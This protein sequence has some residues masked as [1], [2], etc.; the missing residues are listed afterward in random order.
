MCLVVR[1]SGPARHWLPAV[2]SEIRAID[3]NVPVADARSMEEALRESV[4][5]PQFRTTAL[6]LSLVRHSFLVSL[7]LSG[8]SSRPGGPCASIL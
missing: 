8:V 6:Q 3:P 1:T 5:L 7:P 4:A 2:G